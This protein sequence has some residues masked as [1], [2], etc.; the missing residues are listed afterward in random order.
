MAALVVASVGG[1]LLARTRVPN[2]TAG[3]CCCS[4]GDPRA[5]VSARER[6]DW[7][8]LTPL[9]PTQNSRF[10]GIGNQLETLLLAPLLAGAAS[11]D[12]GSAC[13]ASAR[14]VRSAC[15]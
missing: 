8:A 7:V 1:G 13:S 4:S 14:S 2:A 11:Q 3:C 5:P 10:W 15:S 6:P 12:A 9:G